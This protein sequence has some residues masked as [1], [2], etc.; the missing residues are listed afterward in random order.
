MVGFVLPILIFGIYLLFTS[1]FFSFLDICFFGLL[2]FGAK[3]G[4]I[5]SIYFYMTILLIV[6]VFLFIRKEKKN[7][8]YGYFFFFLI[9]SIPL[10][11]LYHFQLLWIFFL[12]IFLKNHDIHYQ[13]KLIGL[14]LWIGFL[15]ISTMY[16]EIGKAPYPNSISHFEYRFLPKRNIQY[17]KMGLELMNKY[18]KAVFIDPNAHYFKI[19]LNQKI[20]K[21]DLINMGNN[22]YHGSDK[23]IQKIK[24]LDGEYVFFVNPRE[25]GT[26]KQTDQKL[27]RY[28]MKQGRL[29]EKTPI[30]DVYT[31]EG[32]KND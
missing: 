6:I 9:N 29:I 13:P 24:E 2:D 26:K 30:Y 17:T 11:D 16:S 8:D 5:R 21:L 25:L 4:K 1:S 10:F 27:I 22:G 20:T 18:P 19:I 15:F 31:L 14:S 28:I 32:E 3:N 12:I 23:L 7:M